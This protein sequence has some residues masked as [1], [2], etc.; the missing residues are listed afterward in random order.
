MRRDFEESGWSNVPVPFGIALV[1]AGV[2]PARNGIYAVVNEN[3][4]FGVIIPAVTC[5]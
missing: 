2:P 1:L 3:A 5:Q 4:E